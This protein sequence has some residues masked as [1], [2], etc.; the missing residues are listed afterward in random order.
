MNND[1]GDRI[2]KIISNIRQMRLDKNYT[3]DYMA[4]K[5]NISQN[6]Y[7]KLE[8]GRSSLSLDRLFQIS[9]VLEIEISELFC[10]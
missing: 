9:A 1:S 10:N 7:S 5:L 2:K 8:L 6:A 3:Q 4:M